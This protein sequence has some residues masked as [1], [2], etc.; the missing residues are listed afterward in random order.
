MTFFL[1]RLHEREY[2][3]QKNLLRKIGLI[4]EMLFHAREN[5]D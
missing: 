1:F 2:R 5:A 4:I 3:V